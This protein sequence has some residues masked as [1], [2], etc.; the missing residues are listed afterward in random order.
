MLE[1][2]ARINAQ[3]LTCSLKPQQICVPHGV[4]Q[5]IFTLFFFLFLSWE[6]KQNTDCPRGKQ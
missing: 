1:K 5:T 4:K 2:Y 6:E 3:M